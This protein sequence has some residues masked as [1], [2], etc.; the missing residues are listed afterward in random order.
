MKLILASKEKFLLE[1]GYDLLGISKKDL[2]IGMIITS[3]KMSDEQYIKYMEEYI[4]LMKLEGID[5]KEFDID[6][7]TETE[8][9]E[10]FKDRNVIQ[11]TGGSPFFFLKKV[12]ESGFDVVLKDLLKEGYSY[13]GCSSGSS[14]MTPSME[15][16]TWKIGRN[17]LGV[18]DFTTLK[19]VPF[20]I[21]SHY[22]DN[23]KEEIIEKM[24]TLKYPL[25]VLKDDQC[26]LVEDGII[27]FYG[28][29][30]EVILN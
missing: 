7:K 27:T 5:F 24:K 19:Y 17:R 20:L 30:E 4:N 26:F 3:V 18:T 1:K 12:R 21:K 13:I 11:V 25:K 2:K 8:I 9:R 16:S 29:S 22:T 6:G 15:I 14:L 28:N 10:F 23:Q